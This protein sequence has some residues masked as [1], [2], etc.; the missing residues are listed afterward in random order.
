MLSYTHV[1]T[2]TNWTQRGRGKIRWE[3]RQH[4]GVGIVEG[5]PGKDESGRLAWV[6]MI[7]LHVFT[8]E[9][10]KEYAF[11]ALKGKSN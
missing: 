8:Y 1:H 4:D 7:S 6:D 9:I 2:G 11:K 10:T 5:G 3:E